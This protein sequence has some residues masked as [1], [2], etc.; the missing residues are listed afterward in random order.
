MYLRNVK[1]GSEGLTTERE[2]LSWAL[3]VCQ[4]NVRRLVVEGI[5]N[6]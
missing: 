6:Y 3:D 4:R 2:E 5:T 1:E